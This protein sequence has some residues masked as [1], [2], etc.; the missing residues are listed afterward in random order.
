M[1][2]PSTIL[3][4]HVPWENAHLKKDARHQFPS[5][6]VFSQ[7]GSCQIYISWFDP[8]P[9]QWMASSRPGAVGISWVSGRRDSVLGMNN[10]WLPLD[11]EGNQSSIYA[12][13]YIYTMYTYIQC[14]HIYI[15][16]MYI[17]YQHVYTQNIDTQWRIM[18]F[19]MGIVWV[20]SRLPWPLPRQ[21]SW[22]WP[23]FLRIHLWWPRTLQAFTLPFF[24]LRTWLNTLW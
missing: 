20:F 16:T 8:M 5:S 2:R 12:Y 11:L 24:L 10:K 4:Y 21:S 18:Y 13:R 7:S 15:Y 3:K 14:I 23:S 6:E 1:G 9:L 17:A 22:S 19:D